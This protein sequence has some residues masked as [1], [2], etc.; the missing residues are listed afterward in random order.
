MG[1]YIPLIHFIVLFLMS[2]FSRNSPTPNERKTMIPIFS[3]TCSRSFSGILPAFHHVTSHPLPHRATSCDDQLTDA[4]AELKAITVWTGIIARVI[5][6]GAQ[7]GYVL[8]R[9]ME[10]NQSVTL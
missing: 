5:T 7:R 4:P 8:E 1:W 9:I 10:N 3:S 2:I 6:L